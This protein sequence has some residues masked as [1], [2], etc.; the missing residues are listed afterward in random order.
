M[1]NSN[2]ILIVDDDSS[3]LMALISILQPEYKVYTAK[4]GA[5]ALDKAGMLL[6]DLVLLDVIM[7]D[8]N[9]FDVIAKL[10]KTDKIKE[11]PVIFITGMNESDTEG[12][13][14]ALGAADYIHKPFNAAVVKERI[15]RQIQIVNQK[16]DMLIAVEE[17]ES[18]V[19]NL[20]S[21]YDGAQF[22]A[23]REKLQFLRERL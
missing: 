17:I 10:K 20:E 15:L 4:S 8:M 16:R 5:S 18:S 11:I 13:G 6:P 12:T 2:I 3:N 1:E 7:P 14:L 9:G 22:A 21:E 19:K 23:L